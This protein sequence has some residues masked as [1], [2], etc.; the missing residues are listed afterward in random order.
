MNLHYII[1]RIYWM[2]FQNVPSN[3]NERTRSQG[4]V[5]RSAPVW[6]P[7]TSS[8]T[9]QECRVKFSFVVRKHHCRACGR[10][11]CSR[12]SQ[13]QAALHY[14]GGTLGRVCQACHGEI[15]SNKSKPNMR[16]TKSLNDFDKMKENISKLIR[17]QQLAQVESAEQD[18][19]GSITSFISVLPLELLSKILEFLPFEDIKQCRLVC[20]FWQAVSLT[21][22][23]SR[24][25]VNL[26]EWVE[27]KVET[28]GIVT[29]Q[30]SFKHFKLHN[31]PFDGNNIPLTSPTT[32]ILKDCEVRP[33]LPSCRLR[34]CC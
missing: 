34:Y 28:L 20:R 18:T 15:E 6:V 29:S 5:G 24:S 9:C 33:C 10:L 31:F 26:P 16:R 21:D 25:Y 4:S 14:L 11:L 13:H 17:S 32:L 12:C 30:T 3:M 2:S 8:S 23:C 22:F 7:D 27:E 1:S 19:S